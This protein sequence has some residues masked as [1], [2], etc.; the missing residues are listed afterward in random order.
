MGVAKRLLNGSKDYL[1][2]ENWPKRPEYN[3]KKGNVD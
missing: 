2:N 1:L 3:S